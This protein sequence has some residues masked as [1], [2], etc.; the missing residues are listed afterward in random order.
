MK[1]KF[2]VATLA[3]TLVIGSASPWVNDNLL[4]PIGLSQVD[5]V[6]HATG[7]GGSITP[8]RP[9]EETNDSAED[10]SSEDKALP[11][12]DDFVTGVSYNNDYGYAIMEINPERLN[13]GF[14]NQ[15]QHIGIGNK[16]IL[17]EL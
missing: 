4:K 10:V 13:G 1:R 3:L 16:N 6:A 11:L 14:V 8:P 7:G 12:T 17:T 2:I 5:T 15:I 9:Q